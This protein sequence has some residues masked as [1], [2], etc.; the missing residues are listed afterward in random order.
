MDTS[1]IDFLIRIDIPADSDYLKNYKKKLDNFLDNLIES[2]SNDK[3]EFEKKLIKVI[4]NTDPKLKTIHP[5]YS[6][7]ITAD[8]PL[9]PKNDFLA[10]SEL[11][12]VFDILLTDSIEFKELYNLPKELP[13]PS[14]HLN[15]VSDMGIYA[16]TLYENPKS[17]ISYSPT[18]NKFSVTTS[19]EKALIA[20]DNGKIIS[21]LDLPNKFL[22]LFSSLR[23]RNFELKELRIQFNKSESKNRNSWFSISHEE[24]H[25][26]EGPMWQALVYKLPPSEI[27]NEST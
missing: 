6:I 21:I 15:R 16:P 8:S 7:I 23:I 1:A 17:S 20:H 3:K 4:F 9:F 19:T 14:M 10:L 5:I 12:P 27:T 13:M 26:I 2:N 22:V 18:L 24:C 11:S 25:V